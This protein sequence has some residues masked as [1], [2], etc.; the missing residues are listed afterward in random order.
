[1]EKL[2]GSNQR[3]VGVIAVAAG[4][5]GA[6]SFGLLV[7][8]LVA[9]AGRG[10]A[11]GP[12]TVL[13][14]GQDIAVALQA[15]LMILVTLAT[16]RYQTPLR[17]APPV[18]GVGIMGQA[19]VVLSIALV[20]A[21]GA[22]WADM[23]YML[24]QGLI[25]LWLISVCWSASSL[26]RWLKV[27]GVLAGIGLV[28][29]AVSDVII[30]N[31]LGWQ[32]FDLSVRTRPSVSAEAISSQGNRLGHTILPIGTLLGRILYPIWTI[33]IGYNLIRHSTRNERLI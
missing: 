7:S 28:L 16:L 11:P 4:C 13:F 17:Q 33:A 12:S 6:V 31:A 9:S 18:T 32:I 2:N 24:P 30:A 5:I 20:F 19:G 14:R 3:R 21:F 15:L 27:V 1:M 26:S 8:G 23:L 25:G 10:R 22:F 29:V